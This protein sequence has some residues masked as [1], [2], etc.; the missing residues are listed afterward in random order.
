MNLTDTHCHLFL[1]EFD[2]DRDEMIRR[3]MDTGVSRFFLPHVD[4][5]SSGGLLSLAGLYPDHCFPLMGLHPTSVNENF[6]TELKHA[7]DLLD[8]GTFY[9]IGEIGMDL[10][11]D[12][13]FRSQQ[14]E[15]FLIQ[16]EWAWQRNIP[17]IVHVR[18]SYD[19]TLSV[20]RKAKLPGLT[21]IFHCFYGTAE[22]AGEII[23]MGF[24]L[25]IGGV[26]TFK[27]SSLAKVL[28]GIDPANI[29]L[30]TDSP[31]LAPVPFRGKRNEPA[32]LVHIVAKLSEIYGLQPDDIAEI[33]TR[34]SEVL[35]K[36]QPFVE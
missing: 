5:R 32:Y 9:G 11:W 27:N 34:N 21:G 13:T 14:E 10:Y 19:E 36:L 3:A 22:Q 17:A 6:V 25:G 30:E 28:A 24:L 4:S 20:I 26:V 29:V 15:A 7:K 2:A 31:Y 8:S 12:Q 18:N 35:F 16:L 23:E 33:T 1:P